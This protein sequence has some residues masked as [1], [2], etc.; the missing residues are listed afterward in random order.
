[1]FFAFLLASGPCRA[2]IAGCLPLAL[3][4]RVPLLAAWQGGGADYCVMQFQD[5]ELTPDGVLPHW[6][7][8]ARY[9]RHRS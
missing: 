5:D 8:P 3:L 2:K 7:L 9:V 4:F 6:R 1:M